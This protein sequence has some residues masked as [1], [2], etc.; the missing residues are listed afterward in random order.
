MTLAQVG[1]YMPDGL[2][3]MSNLMNMLIEAAQACKVSVVKSPGW[4]SIG[5]KLDG[6][7]YWVGLDMSEP[8]KLWFG[9]R[10]Q[11]DREKVGELGAGEQLTEET[12]VSGRYRWWRGVELDS[13]EVHFFSRSK[14]SQMQW[15]EEFIRDC[16]AKARSIETPDQPPMPDEPEDVG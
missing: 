16:L 6:Q 9:T 8:E 2:R 10:V 12:W 13:E 7:K 1:K 5:V 4:D 15:L 3:A 11:I 14:L